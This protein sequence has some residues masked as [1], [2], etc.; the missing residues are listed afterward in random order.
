MEGRKL[1]EA[2]SK[3][4][5]DSHLRRYI[6]WVNKSYGL[7]IS[8]DYEELHLWSIENHEIFWESLWKYF[9]VINHRSYD[10][11]TNGLEM[12]DTRWFLHSHINYA[13][14]IFRNSTDEFPALISKSEIR[15]TAEISWEELENKVA[16]LQD[17]YKKLDIEAGDCIAGFLPNIPEATISFLAAN[18]LGA[19]WSC[20]SPDFGVESVLDRFSQIQ[21]RILI[22]TDGYKYGGKSFDR[23]KVIAE[24]TRRIPSI[25]KVIVIPYLNA[26]S[27]EWDD[28][29]YVIWDSLFSGHPPELRFTPV[30]FNHPMWVLY[31]SGTTG[32]PKAI[33]H[34]H[35]GMLLE[36]FKYMAFHNDVNRGERFFWYTTTGWMMWNFVQASL[37]CGATAV[38]YDGSAG[39]PD[40]SVLWDFASEVGIHHFGTSAP[41]IIACM[42]Y[43]IH[44]AGDHRFE[45]LRSIGSTGSHLPPEGFDW[46]YEHIKRDVWLCS[47]SGG[48]DVCTAFVGGCILK[49]VLEGYIQCR[50][51]GVS[52]FAYDDE[53]R[54]LWDETGEMVITRPMPAMPV[55]FWNDEGNKRYQE[56]YFEQYPGVWRHGDWVEI[57]RNGMLKILGRSDATLNRHGVRIGTA[58]IY[59]VINNFD[60]I[61]DSL[62]VNLELTSGEHYM[63]IFIKMIPGQELTDDL[64]R[65][66]SQKLRTACSPRHV[67]DRFIQVDDIPYTISGKKMEAPVKKILLGKDLHG[68]LSPDA[69]RN[70]D[71]LEIY[72]KMTK[73]K[74][75]TP[76]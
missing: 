26:D 32:I 33:T 59:E 60:Q 66:V 55:Y 40:I 13:E 38:L 17:F 12:P 31:S 36:H 19:I 49:P 73:N 44:P 8:L 42:K 50:A 30:D 65:A 76:T 64:I 43:G 20:C 15:E 34:S 52:L 7:Q 70:P 1:W 63:P 28:E 4:I 14:H 24:L 39:Y 48:T 25:E 10:A 53:G 18:S 6:D 46:I 47:M 45:H 21:P 16:W 72:Q 22:A 67:P 61:E 62:V 37:L 58:E 29:K 51:L 3:T 75:F 11:V 23:Y 54:E 27:T 9:N 71:S 74:E 56:S 35:G 68:S 57:A 5:Q 69:M 41:F 2:D